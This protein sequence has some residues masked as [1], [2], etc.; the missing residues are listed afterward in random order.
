LTHWPADD[1]RVLACGIAEAECGVPQDYPSRQASL[2]IIADLR[3]Q[4]DALTEDE[5]QRILAERHFARADLASADE[6]ANLTAEQKAAQK[7]DEEDAAYREAAQIAVRASSPPCS[8]FGCSRA[9]QGVKISVPAEWIPE[10]VECSFE[11]L[12]D[13][14]AR[15]VSI[16]AGGRRNFA[17]DDAGVLYTWGIG[18]SGEMGIGSQLAGSNKDVQ[19]L[20]RIVPRLG[21]YH[22]VKVAAGSAHTFVLAYLREDPVPAPAKVAD[23]DAK[24]TGTS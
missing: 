12:D 2:A 10:P 5:K 22:V 8:G 1:G 18:P 9:T 3:K 16:A 11:H 19:E 14:P 17:L 21:R 7:K 20:P 23:G 15:I 24:L 4:R 13:P 6:P